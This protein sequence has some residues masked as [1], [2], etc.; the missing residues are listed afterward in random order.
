VLNVS[1]QE[2]SFERRYMTLSAWL[3]GFIGLFGVAASLTTD[4]VTLLV[5]SFLYLVDAG[6]AACAVFILR[7]LQ[8]PPDERF[9]FGYHKLEPAVVNASA[10]LLVAGSLIGILFALQDLVHP[11]NIEGYSV[12]LSF[13][14][15][16]FLTSAAMWWL[17]RRS[18]VAGGPPLL[19]AEKLAWGISTLENGGVLAGFCVAFFL[20]YEAPAPFKAAAPFVDPGMALLLSLAIL[21]EPLKTYWESALDLLDATP[22]T[23]A[24]DMVRGAAEAVFA[25]RGDAGAVSGV[26]LRRAGR[27][28]FVHLDLAIPEQMSITEARVLQRELDRAVR[29]ALPETVLV[30]F[31]HESDGEQS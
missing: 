9:H 26:R 3:C 14:A 13:G 7:K 16:A 17:A 19:K 8:N 4:S 22:S 1:T 24:R 6:V 28:A 21:K 5:E 31:A 27:R 12:A 30:T 11:D 20:E 25:S 18:Y 2:G 29:E 10:T 23:H 15:T